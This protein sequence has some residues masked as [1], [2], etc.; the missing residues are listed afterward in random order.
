MG[1][2]PKRQLCEVA[3]L[4]INPTSNQ[5][6][7]NGQ[8]RWWGRVN[9]IRRVWLRL[10]RRWNKISH[11]CLGKWFPQTATEPSSD[12]SAPIGP[13]SAP[14]IINIAQRIP[15]ERE[16]ASIKTVR[17][18]TVS[19]SPFFLVIWIRMKFQEVNVKTLIIEFF[20]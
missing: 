12:S 17:H 9:F 11:L 8:F 15:T 19:S 10:L 7:T 20:V 13:T 1:F 4:G 18:Y 2:T 14:P 6:K 3:V 16:I 5:A